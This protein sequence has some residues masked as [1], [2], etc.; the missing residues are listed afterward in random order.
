MEIR[1]RFLT[2]TRGIQTPIPRGKIVPRC[3]I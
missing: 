3:L 1:Q 2:G